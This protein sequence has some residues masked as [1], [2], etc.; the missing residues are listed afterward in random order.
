MLSFFFE[1]KGH[2]AVKKRKLASAGR[3]CRACVN[4]AYGAEGESWWRHTA[5]P[6][7]HESRVPGPYAKFFRGRRGGVLINFYSALKT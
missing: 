7:G 5:A 6:G 3:G 4:V 2:D 1:R